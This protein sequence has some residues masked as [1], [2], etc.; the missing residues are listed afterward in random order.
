MGFRKFLKGKIE[1][2]GG[3]SG[4][5]KA[6]A[7]KSSRLLKGESTPLP[8]KPTAP[9]MDFGEMLASLPTE[10]DDKGYTAVLPS[11]LLIVG[12]GRTVEAPTGRMVTLFRYEGQ[13]YALDD[14]CTHEDA[15]IGEG[16]VCGS[17]ITCPYH[18]WEF[19]FTT[20]VCKTDPSRPL[21]IFEVAEHDDYVWLGSHLTESSTDRGGAVNDGIAMK[22][23]KP[24]R[25]K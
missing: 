25:G 23:N 14:T 22:V 20:G 5:A 10:P 15:P 17:M 2:H 3:I 1:K 18:E 19:D 16:E 7:D 13:V 4:A 21:A 6:A 8:A 11:G 9:Q 12:A 24:T